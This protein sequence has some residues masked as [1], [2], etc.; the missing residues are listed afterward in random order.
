MSAPTS[1][2]NRPGSLA[3]RLDA[4]FGL[5]ARGTNVRTEVIAGAT[6][7]MTMAYI[8]FVNPAI[9]GKLTDGAGTQL[10]F[11]AVLTSTALVAAV[12]TLAMGLFGNLPLALAAGMGLN[13]VVAF[14]LVA[15]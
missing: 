2:T 4:F 12:M 1:G 7:F 10:A 13:S 14:Q 11:P 9:L 6:T 8:V 15:T 5:T 3:A